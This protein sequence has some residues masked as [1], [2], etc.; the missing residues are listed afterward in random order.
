MSVPSRI[1][2][3]RVGAHVAGEVEAPQLRLFLELA[4]QAV[5]LLLEERRDQVLRAATGSTSRR[6]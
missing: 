4:Q 5:L 1:D 6:C 3:V 2:V